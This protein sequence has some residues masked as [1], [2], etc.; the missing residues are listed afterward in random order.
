MMSKTKTGKT[1]AP[2]TP[3]PE[4]PPVDPRSPAE[5][6]ANPGRDLTYGEILDLEARI[7]AGEA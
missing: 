1:P 6:L 3:A 2:E 5:I 7:K 4:T